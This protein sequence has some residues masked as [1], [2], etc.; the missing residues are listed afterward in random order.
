MQKYPLLLNFFKET[1]FDSDINTIVWGKVFIRL[2]FISLTIYKV[3]IGCIDFCS[4]I[5]LGKEFLYTFL[6]KMF[7]KKTSIKY[8]VMYKS[9]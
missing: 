4:K 7:K 6:N 9:I 5:E 8:L 3:F 2:I 1:H